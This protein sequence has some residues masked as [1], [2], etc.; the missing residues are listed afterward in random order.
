MPIKD[1]QKDK[2]GLSRAGVIRLG[3][4]MRKCTKCG[5]VRAADKCPKC[6]GTKFK[7][8]KRDGREII[9]EFPTQADH[10]VLNDAPDVIEALGTDKPAELR[11][12]FPFDD[13]DLVFP[14]YHQLWSAGALICRGDGEKI[15]Y[16]INPQTGRTIVRDGIALEDFKT[17][18]GDFKRGD[19]MGCP[20]MAH[21]TYSR[22]QNCKPNAMLIVLLRDVPRLA[23][24]QIATTSIH[25]VVNLT[26]QLTYIK[27]EVGRLKGV[28]FIL[29]YGMREISAPAGEG[30]K[31]QRV[32]KYLLSLEVDPEYYRRIVEMQSQLAAPERMLLSDGEF[33]EAETE[34]IETTKPAPE[35]GT[36]EPPM[37]MAPNGGDDS[38]FVTDDW[39]AFCTRVVEE[40]SFYRHKND[41]INAMN[42]NE[43]D[44]DVENEELIFDTLA[45]YAQTQADMD[46]AQQEADGIITEQELPF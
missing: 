31:R 21:D 45:K 8:Y 43:L 30:G 46:I 11:I 1:L 36:I 33:V 41:I 19:V 14:A 27:Q 22:C 34:E 23:Y 26:Q 10:F 25:N 44:Y 39:D 6:N 42:A 12:W 2:P 18:D 15:E 28:P 24:Y 20:G 4:K 32:K 40:I 37:W 16:A 38:E 9:L 3:Y 5:N 29:K 7:S 13:I 17:K 35:I